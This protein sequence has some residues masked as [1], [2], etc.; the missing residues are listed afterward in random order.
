MRAS[1][2]KKDQVVRCPSCLKWP[3]LVLGKHST[4]N[5]KTYLIECNNKLCKTRPS[6]AAYK[7]MRLA[8]DNWN[9]GIIT[10][11]MFKQ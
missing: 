2:S 9:E 3:E 11:N 10:N 6:T 7:T 8:K 4:L 1:L 5:H